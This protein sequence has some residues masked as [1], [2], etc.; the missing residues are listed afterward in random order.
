VIALKIEIDP[1]GV[2]DRQLTELEKTQLPF[3]AIQA[4]NAVAAQIH[5]QWRDVAGK[6]FDR[7]TNFTRTA[8]LYKK[9]TKAK[10]VAEVFIRDE[11]FKGVPP[12][13][14][15][16]AQVF[17]GSR[18]QKG[19][20]KRLSAA[21]ILPAGLFI[22]PGK[23]AKLDASGNIP[24][25]QINAIKSQL[26]V[27]YDPTSN[28]SAA[29]RG[30]RQK[31]ESKARRTDYFA[32]VTPKGGLKPGVYQRI[33]TGFGNGVATIM[34]FVRQPKYRQRYD[35]LKMAQTIFDRRWRPEYKA[36]LE[37]AVESTFKRKFNL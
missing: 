32:V 21:G 25:S 27:Q 12:A 35:I 14:Y 16:Q 13:K 9:A 22:V 1:N 34:R 37:R 36:Q 7:P 19:I 3:A 33:K 8:A 30:R 31:R 2:F 28:E 24:L 18:A 23:G 29:S 5:Y 26:Q 17:G 20:E 10:P 6:V 15:L 4:T 11:A